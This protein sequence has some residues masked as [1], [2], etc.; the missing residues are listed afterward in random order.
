MKSIL[1]VVV[2]VVCVVQLS[3]AV[4]IDAA[5]EQ[6]YGAEIQQLR[7]T[8]NEEVLALGL[9]N[10]TGVGQDGY[11]CRTCYQYISE[12]LVKLELAIGGG[13]MDSCKQLCLNLNGTLEQQI[14]TLTCIYI[15]L[16]GFIK[17][18]NETDPDPLYICSLAEFCPVTDDARANITNVTI[19]PHSTAPQGSTFRIFCDYRVNRTIASGEAYIGVYPPAGAGQAVGDAFLLVEQK[20]GPYVIG[21][22]FEATPNNYDTFVPGIYLVACVVCEGKCGSPHPHSYTL[23]VAEKKIV[24]TPK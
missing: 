9:V 5:V 21:F 1:L 19:T 13:I 22:T 2:L 3:G 7:Q 15:G 24:I 20:P 16:Q 23:S 11:Y 8:I 4:R 12:N 14:C 18:L 6:K 10:D 17:L